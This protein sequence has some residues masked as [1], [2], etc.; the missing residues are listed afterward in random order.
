MWETCAVD[1]RVELPAPVA[2]ELAEVQQKD[3]A[4]LNRMLFYAMTRRAI[5]HHLTARGEAGT[6]AGA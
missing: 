6:E 5:F 4:M 2:A 1:L 3:P